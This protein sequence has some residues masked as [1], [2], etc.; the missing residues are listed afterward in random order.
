MIV[1]TANTTVGYAVSCLLWTIST[2]LN[3]G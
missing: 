3:A 1:G 2:A